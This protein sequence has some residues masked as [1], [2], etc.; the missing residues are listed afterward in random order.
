MRRINWPWAGAFVSAF[1]SAPVLKNDPVVEG[2]ASATPENRL[3]P[4]SQLKL[5]A[6]RLAINRQR[7]GFNRIGEVLGD[8]SEA[9]IEAVAGLL[10]GRCGSIDI[11]GRLLEL[12]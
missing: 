9:G 5:A 2:P 10:E 8:D 4:H 7:L 11:P 12:L 3:S 6:T 1:S